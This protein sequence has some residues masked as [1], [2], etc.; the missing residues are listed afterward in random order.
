[1]S[2]AHP[3][4]P[5]VDDLVQGNAVDVFL[6]GKTFQDR[7]N[8]SVVKRDC[9]QHDLNHRYAFAAHLA[10]RPSSSRV[11]RGDRRS[12][13]PGCRREDHCETTLGCLAK[14]SVER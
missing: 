13:R 3:P 7:N 9:C 6:L 10:S 11:W 12:C 1:M 8:L 4:E 2:A 14:R 5:I